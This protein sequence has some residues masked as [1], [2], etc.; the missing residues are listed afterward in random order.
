[1]SKVQFGVLCGLLMILIGI[2]ALPVFSPART[3]PRYEYEVEDVEDM[4][5]VPRMAVLGSD[6][7]DLIFARRAMN[8]GKDPAYE[9]IF[10]RPL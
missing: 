3:A 2:E 7:W 6:G 8:E 4:K 10:R 5:L 9:M 1:M